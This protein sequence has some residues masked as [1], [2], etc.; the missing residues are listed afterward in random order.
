MLP[1]AVDEV[2]QPRPRGPV[3]VAYRALGQILSA[4]TRRDLDAA[5]GVV[6]ILPAPSTRVTNP[7]DFRDT[8]RL[9]DEGYRMAVRKLIGGYPAENLPSLHAVPAG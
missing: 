7:V 8:T 3:P 2:G 9:I 1:A 4:A 6:H 5:R